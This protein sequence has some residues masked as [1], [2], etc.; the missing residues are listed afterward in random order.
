MGNIRITELADAKLAELWRFTAQ[1]STAAQ[2]DACLDELQRA[3]GQLADGS[4]SGHAITQFFPD[5]PQDILYHSVEDIFVIYR[6]VEDRGIEVL[7]LIHG[8][9]A[10]LLTTYLQSLYE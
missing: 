1:A 3:F 6:L 8:G 7:T 2:A 10:V 5:G 4:T 9:Q